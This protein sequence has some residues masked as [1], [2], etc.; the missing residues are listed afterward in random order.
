MSDCMGAGGEETHGDSVNHPAEQELVSV[1][2]IAGRTAL[3][4]VTVRRH[5]DRA[6]IKPFRLGKAKNA[7]LRYRRSDVE[8]W[9]R[10]CWLD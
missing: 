5:L 8:T 1:K 4:R 6:G 10:S 9:M 3:T 2:W 7:T